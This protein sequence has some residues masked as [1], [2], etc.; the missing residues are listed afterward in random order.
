[1]GEDTTE[2]TRLEASSIVGDTLPHSNG[3]LHVAES[4]GQLR[5]ELNQVDPAS[6]ADGSLNM[7]QDRGEQDDCEPHAVDVKILESSTGSEANS[8]IA[9]DAGGNG[10]DWSNVG[11]VSGWSATVQ[12]GND[13]GWGIDTDDNQVVLPPASL[14]PVPEQPWAPP[15]KR[16]FYLI[17]IPR[18][19]DNKIK[20]E[21]RVADMLLEETNKKRDFLRIALQMKRSS[22]AD[23]LEQLKPIRDKE[24]ACRDAI[25]G[26]RMELE[27]FLLALAQ[28]KNAHG[29][30]RG[31]GQDLCSSEEELND[32]IASIQYRI[33]HESISLKEEKQLL[34]EIKQ[35]EATRNQVCANT[36]LQAELV[37]NLG[38]REDIQDQYRLLCQELD[39]M[40]KQ[41]KEIR[42]EYEVIDKDIEK[43]NASIE[44]L[45]QQFEKANG[46]QQEAYAT[47]R[48][49]RKQEN[50]KNDIFYKNK[51]DSQAARELASQKNFEALEKFCLDQVEGI[52]S[53]WNVDSKFRSEYVKA[54]E[55]STVKR[56]ETLDGRSLGPDEEP[57]LLLSEI[58]SLSGSL[59]KSSDNRPVVGLQAAALGARVKS[60]NVHNMEVKV[61]DGAADV[62]SNKSSKE[63]DLGLNLKDSENA[64]K[65]HIIPT[66]PVIVKSAVGNSKSIKKES[67]D[68]IL[69]NETQAAELKERRRQ[70]EMAK[71]KEAA[72]RKKKRAEK[73]ESKAL[74]RAKKEA[75]RKEKDK[76]KKARKKAAAGGMQVSESALPNVETQQDSTEAAVPLK[77]EL[78]NSVN[79]IHKVQRGVPSAQ[80][81]KPLGKKSKTSRPA[82]ANPFLKKATWPI[83]TWVLILLSVLMLLLILVVFM[84]V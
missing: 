28:F 19:I 58:D 50:A 78:G 10:S 15:K 31:R 57:P 27:P 6:V 65:A 79:E 70:E 66:R 12:E 29:T 2:N 7:N 21:I 81:R 13:S 23:L 51:R 33:Q 59:P 37:E 36:V 24:K 53:L 47:F 34:R 40:R 48:E 64:D 62:P 8:Q 63:T 14:T 41:H 26:K 20:N 16:I 83:P 22:K 4:S 3:A 80:W 61:S 56:L 32:K 39:S 68:D 77:K 75:E 52:F 54:N 38:P 18:V 17:R 82:L 45:R 11:N 73:A 72:E 74:M 60:S 67:Q 1:M 71:A 25:Q 55:R 5:N 35:L 46:A 30:V 9:A 44:E 42:T 49:L 84:N 69:E 76:E 43:L